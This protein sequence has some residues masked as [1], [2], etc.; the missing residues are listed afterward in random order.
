MMNKPTILLI[1]GTGK[2]GKRIAQQLDVKGVDYSLA[3]RNPQ[4]PQ[5]RFFDWQRPETNALFEGILS[6]YIVAPTHTSEHQPIVTPVLQQALD[7]GV[8]RFVL[9]S[10]SSL[11][12]DGPAMGKIHAF[13]HQHAPE[14][15]VLRPTWF[16]QNLSEQH[17][18]ATIKEEGKIYSATGNGRIGFVDAD[19]IARS[20]VAALLAPLAPNADFILTGPKTLSY[21]DI[22]RLLSDELGYPVDH[23]SLTVD[24]LAQ[25][26]RTMG[27][28]EEYAQLL[29]SMDESISQGAEDRLSEGVTLLTNHAPGDIAHYIA[30]E[31]QCWLR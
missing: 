13:L 22:A 26:Y 27:M 18:Q 30:R 14:W 20:A 28:D 31:R 16:M 2:T 6:V 5:D 4:R 23:I 19:D 8:K 24:Q 25:R 11:E 15:C 9:L 12:E 21:D 17:H 29:A 7:Q 3:T 10:A 1:G